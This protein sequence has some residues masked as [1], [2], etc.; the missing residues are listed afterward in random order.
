MSKNNN[1]N[2]SFAYSD[3][4][5]NCMTTYSI[6]KRDADQFQN[7]GIDLDKIEDFNGMLQ[8]F[9]N[10]PQDQELEADLKFS[11][12]TKNNLAN[13]LRINIRMFKARAMLVFDDKSATYNRFNNGNLSKL[14]DRDLY[15]FAEV[16]RDSAQ[17]YLTE[18]SDVGLTQEIIDEFAAL[19]EQFYSAMYEQSQAKTNRESRTSQRASKSNELYSL[20][21]KYCEIGKTIWYEI[22]EAKYNDYL[23]Y[24]FRPKKS[25][26]A[27]KKKVD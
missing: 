7:Y 26:K 9:I 19:I 24:K 23:I 21:V 2:F 16:V 17:E 22:N 14:N 3:L 1:R 13:D 11:T 15:M 10:F 12:Y 18:L 6:M 25:K 5:G 20:M 8:D 4:I 27:I